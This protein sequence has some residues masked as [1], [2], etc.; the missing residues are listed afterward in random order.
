MHGTRVSWVGYQQTDIE[1]S[2]RARARRGA[3]REAM[4]I[5]GNAGVIKRKRHSLAEIADKLAQADVLIAQGRRNQEVAHAL[6][7]SVMTFHRWRKLR[8]R[9]GDQESETSV[10]T[11]P[12]DRI[13]E[14]DRLREIAELQLENSRLRRLVTDLMLE[15]IKL[16]ENPSRQDPT[17]DPTDRAAD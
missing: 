1:S 13:S 12:V 17:C 10:R 2:E 15:K 5:W 7:V 6:G 9:Q 11:R 16:E 8:P 14:P 3:A 4:M